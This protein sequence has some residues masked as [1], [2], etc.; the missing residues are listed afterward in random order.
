LSLLK[1][2][3]APAACAF[4]DIALLA[5]AAAINLQNSLRC[6]GGHPHS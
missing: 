1:P 2:D 6:I 3:V 4:A 5:A